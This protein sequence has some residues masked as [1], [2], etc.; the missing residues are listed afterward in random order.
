MIACGTDCFDVTF[1]ADTDSYAVGPMS[2]NAS[3]VPTTSSITIRC[4]TMSF[5]GGNSV[6]NRDFAVMVLVP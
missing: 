4:W 1:T 2:L 5:A 6:V 3:P